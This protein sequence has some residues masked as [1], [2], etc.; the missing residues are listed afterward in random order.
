[1]VPPVRSAGDTATPNSYVVHN[2][3]IGDIMTEK[4]SEKIE[5]FE[6]VQSKIEKIIHP[7]ITVKISMPE[8][9]DKEAFLKLENDPEFITSLTSQAKYWLTKG[10]RR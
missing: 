2:T 8:G 10:D 5:K 3:L 6:K 1:M 9:V 4:G 7:Y